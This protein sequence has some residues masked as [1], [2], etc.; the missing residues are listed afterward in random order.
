MS[1][2]RIVESKLVKD[3]EEI[4]GQQ[5]Q[6]NRTISIVELPGGKYTV[7]RSNLSIGIKVDYN[8]N[9]KSLTPPTTLKKA[10]KA[11]EAIK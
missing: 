4:G 7:R 10:R 2:T 3:T 5:V 11:Y 8:P 6:V 1:K 9:G